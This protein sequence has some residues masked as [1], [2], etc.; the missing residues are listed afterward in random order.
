MNEYRAYVVGNDGHFI[1]FTGLV[2]D[3]DSEAIKQARWLVGSLAID[4]WSGERFVT[5]LE[6]QDR[7][8]KSIGI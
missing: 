3:D 2:C 5:R 4:L 7:S 8:S 1:N 6:S